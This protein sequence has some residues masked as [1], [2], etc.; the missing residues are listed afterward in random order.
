VEAVVEESE[1]KNYCGEIFTDG[2][3]RC[4]ARST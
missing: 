4:S 3:I 1:E 2:R